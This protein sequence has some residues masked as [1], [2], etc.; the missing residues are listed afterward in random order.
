M[1]RGGGV[2]LLRPKSGLRQEESMDRDIFDSVMA[3]VFASF[4]KRT[5]PD[6][7]EVLFNNVSAHDN[8]FIAWA[9]AQLMDYEKLPLNIGRELRKVLLPAWELLQMRRKQREALEA[10]GVD[11]AQADGFCKSGK[12]GCPE[13]AGAAGADGEGWIYAWPAGAKPGSAPTAFPCVCNFMVDSLFQNAEVRKATR[14]ELEAE[15]WSLR[16]PALKREH[17]SPLKLSLEAF[18]QRVADAKA[19]AANPAAAGGAEFGMR[20]PEEDGGDAA[21]A[22]A[23]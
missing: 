16:E 6:M 17:P 21:P 4:Q 15:G 19:Q 11:P 8:E 20:S 7:F 2:L 23:W 3:D 22:A 5:N 12:P 10:A 14:A 13:C 18:L 9:G 1:R